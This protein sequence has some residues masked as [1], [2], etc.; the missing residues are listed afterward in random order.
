VPAT[1]LHDSP[2]CPTP[3]ERQ[4]GRPGPGAQP[5]QRVD[6]IVGALAARRAARQARVDQP[7]CGILA[8]HARDE[9]QWPAPEGLAGYTGQASA[10][11]GFRVRKAPPFFASSL[12]RK[13]PA[14]MMALLR[15]RPVCVLVSAAFAS[16][17]RH[18]LQEPN[19]TFPDHTGKRLQTPTARG[20]LH[21]CGGMHVLY[22]PGPGLMRLPLTDEHQPLLQLLGKRYAWFYR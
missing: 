5:A 6:R 16:R 2:R 17:I 18:A 4:R 22:I 1:F 15:V 12:S 19:A 3:Q 10:A 21:D 13:K 11:R 8:T 20:V 9:G 14:R 7:S